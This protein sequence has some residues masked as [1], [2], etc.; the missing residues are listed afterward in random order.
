MIKIT[1]EYSPDEIY[2]VKNIATAEFIDLVRDFDIPR[3]NVQSLAEWGAFMYLNSKIN[4]LNDYIN[5]FAYFREEI[6]LEGAS[7][8]DELYDAIQE[9]AVSNYF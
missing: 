3:E 4:V 1:I 6:E 9:Y 8:D 2:V 5:A 7:L